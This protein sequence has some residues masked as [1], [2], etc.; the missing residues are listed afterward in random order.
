MVKKYSALLIVSPTAVVLLFNLLIFNRYFPL[1]EGWWET[2]AYLMN[3]G[4]K[5]FKD[6]DLALSPLFV[7][8]NAALLKITHSSFFSIR[9]IGAFAFTVTV[10]FMQL[11]LRQFF[12]SFVSSLAALFSA[13]LFMRS[14][15]F[16][17][18]DYHTYLHLLTIIWLFL[19]IKSVSRPRDAISDA[20]NLSIGA[21]LAVIFFLKQ[22]VGVL[23]FVAILLNSL[24]FTTLYNR[25][26]R[27]ICIV[28]GFVFVFL[29]I[30][31]VSGFD[32]L[33]MI[34]GNDSKGG[35]VTVIFRF[36]TESENR[37][38]IIY[39]LLLVIVYIALKSFS[40]LSIAIICQFR[41]I[42]FIQSINKHSSFLWVLL[43][44]FVVALGPMRAI[45]LQAVIPIALSVLLI[46][47]YSGIKYPSSTA[48]TLEQKIVLLPLCA[49][50][51]ANTNTATFDFI[52][53]FEV[54]A[55][56]SGALLTM[57]IRTST[58]I[59][60]FFATF[61]ILIVPYVMYS[62]LMKPYEW[63]GNHQ[64]GVFSAI[65]DAGYPEL[66]GIRLDAQT[67]RAFKVTAGE[68]ERYSSSQ[69]DV[70]FFNLPLFYLLEHKSLIGRL[71]IQWFD[72]V[73]TAQIEKDLENLRTHHPSVV[74]IYEPSDMAFV[75]HQSMKKVDEL[76]QRT[77]IN[78]VDRWVESGDYIFVNS[79]ALQSPINTLGKSKDV[80][81]DILL[82]ESK[83]V[84]LTMREILSGMQLI[85]RSVD[86]LGVR[87]HGKLIPE[88]NDARLML[89]D[90][91]VVRGPLRNVTELS[92]HMG[93]ARGQGRTWNTIS[94]YVERDR[95][96][97]KSRKSLVI[98]N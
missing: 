4:L 67:Q 93:V 11:F 92:Q 72:V 91:I 90:T 9:L 24:F 6:L 79:V 76:V 48:F 81:L 62:K 45:A 15:Q 97:Q 3:N 63:W 31:I 16:I 74:V 57:A 18:K 68:I 95:F 13:F 86:V 7:V 20:I 56:G 61:M 22:N 35:M 98:A 47:F 94:I 8:Y 36:L 52:G 49:L 33:G 60:Y 41:D 34:K 21:V 66:K 37:T 69:S 12:S 59:Q 80:D 44:V 38:I 2:Y 30:S 70:Y 53:C 14:P 96:E 64:G 17:A 19:L 71:P 77:L 75:V 27:F 1:S 73:T 88:W 82:Q 50:A 5:L 23:L 32:S 78:Q 29:Y 65:Y 46:Y 40:K 26:A 42:K 25:L 85:R 55:Y 28:V 10:M 87:R 83:M 51:Y 39:S 43:G 84:N 58:G 54:I 89:G